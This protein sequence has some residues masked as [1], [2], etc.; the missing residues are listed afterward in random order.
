MIA[1]MLTALTRREWLAMVGLAAAAACRNA[2][3]PATEQSQAKT[4]LATVTLIVDGM[5]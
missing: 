2:A 4:D 5:L 1:F 3:K